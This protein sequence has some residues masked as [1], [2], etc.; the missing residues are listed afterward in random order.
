ERDPQTAG[1]QRVPA[2]RC[3]CL[4]ERVDG[5]AA[6]P[7]EPELVAGA[8]EGLQERISVPG[9][10]VA[11]TRAFLLA[12]RARVPGQLGTCDQELLVEVRRRGGDHPGRTVAPLQADAAGRSERSAR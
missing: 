2:G 1:E 5:E 8:L 6:A 3:L 11:E 7:L 12:V 9:S 4:R 10:A